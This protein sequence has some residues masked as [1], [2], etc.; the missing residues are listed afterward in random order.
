MLN[1]RRACATI[2]DKS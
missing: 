2:L 1:M